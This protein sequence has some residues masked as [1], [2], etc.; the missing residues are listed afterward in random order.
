MLQA[1]IGRIV[2]CAHA[3]PRS[4]RFEG[5]FTDWPRPGHRASR[6]EAATG[7][8]LHRA[9]DERDVS[10]YSLVDSGPGSGAAAQDA[11]LWQAAL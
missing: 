5:A 9:T 6:S 8:T 4:A 7:Q 10:K 1:G 11:R 2:R 3:L